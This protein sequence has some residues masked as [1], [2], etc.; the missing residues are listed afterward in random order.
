MKILWVL[1][2]LSNSDAAVNFTAVTIL[3][4]LERIQSTACVNSRELRLYYA[5]HTTNV[6]LIDFKGN[7][8]PVITVTTHKVSQETSVA[9]T[10]EHFK[11]SSRI[12]EEKR[13]DIQTICI[14]TTTGD[15]LLT[16]NHATGRSQFSWP[17]FI[18]LW[19][20]N[21]LCWAHPPLYMNK[22]TACAHTQPIRR[23][24]SVQ[25]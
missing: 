24:D 3:Q 23:A 25:N 4:V 20:S 12:G 10:S 18:S 9:T 16:S 5:R 14:D 2:I 7:R 22:H 15:N 6:F 11:T 19:I 8:G 13:E 17:V 1:G 21:A